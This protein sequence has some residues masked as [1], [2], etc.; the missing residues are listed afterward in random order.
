MSKLIISFTLLFLLAG[1]CTKTGD[2]TQG[3]LLCWSEDKAI[4][5]Q[6]DLQNTLN[7]EEKIKDKLVHKKDDLEEKRLEKEAELERQKQMLKDLDGELAQIEETIR[8]TKVQTESKLQEKKKAEWTVKKLKNR[9]KS[10]N[11]NNTLSVKQKQAKIDS[12]NKEVD[13]LMGIIS[14]L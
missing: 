2:P 10:L 12:L 8:K 14:A 11:S 9:I 5:R 4:E 7:E 13:N 3:G 1:C 6:N